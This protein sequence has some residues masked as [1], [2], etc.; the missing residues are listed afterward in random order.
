[1][2]ILIRSVGAL[3]GLVEVAAVEYIGQHCAHYKRQGDTQSEISLTHTHPLT[4]AP[5]DPCASAPAGCPRLL[6]PASGAVPRLAPAHAFRQRPRTPHRGGQA[7][8]PT[9]GVQQE[10]GCWPPSC[11]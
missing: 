8:Q 5:T 6:A 9:A 10:E 2:T 4:L 3:V 7:L 11:S 1:G